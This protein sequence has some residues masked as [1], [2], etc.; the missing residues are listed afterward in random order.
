MSDTKMKQRKET[1]VISLCTTLLLKTLDFSVI[2]K[3]KKIQQQQ[4]HT[5]ISHEEDSKEFL[6]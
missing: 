2:S 6:S 5:N 4:T 3:I 1:T